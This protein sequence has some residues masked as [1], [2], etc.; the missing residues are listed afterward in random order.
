M[1]STHAHVVAEPTAADRPPARTWPALA[2]AVGCAAAYAVFLVLPYYVNDLQR[3]PLSEV[4][5]GYH[6]PKDLWPHSTALGPVFAFGGFFTLTLAPF[7]AFCT[8]AWAV[9]T[10]VVARAAHGWRERTSLF[11]AATVSLGTLAWL[12]TPFAEA[13]MGWFLD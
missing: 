1:S 4:A 11:V 5:V 2:L 7:V 6:D 3:F 9:V 10:L 8:L 12:T 13:L